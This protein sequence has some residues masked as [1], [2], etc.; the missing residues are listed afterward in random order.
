MG[1]PPI[2]VGGV[3]EIRPRQIKDRLWVVRVRWRDDAGDYHRT[4]VE[5]P[6][7]RESED[8]AA[9]RV[10][11]A[12]E[13]LRQP[14]LVDLTLDEVATRCFDDMR[15]SRRRPSTIAQYEATWRGT[16]SPILG[17]EPV[18]A[19]TRARVQQVLLGGLFARHQG[20]RA[21]DGSWVPGEYRLDESG[22]RIPLQGAQPRNVLRIVL[23][24]AADRGLRTDGVNPLDGTETP[25]R[26]APAVRALTDEESTHLIE[27]AAHWHR[28][29]H[30]ASDVL[31]HGLVLLRYG[32][33]RLG[34][35]LAL[36]WDDID[37]AS[38]PPTM[39]V[40]HTL[41]EQRGTVGGLGPT[42][43]G[44]VD[45]I[46]LHPAAM[47]I[48]LSRRRASDLGP[49][50]FATRTGRPVTQANF[51]RALRDLVRGTDLAWVHPHAFRKSL[52]TKADAQ[53]NLDAAR[54]LLRHKDN[55]VTRRHY[56][57]RADVRI[58]DPRS[59]FE[60]TEGCS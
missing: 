37:L 7:K 21:D 60:Q 46:A 17:C 47:T 38:D 29:G 6:S 52:A 32:G 19:I 51:R 26:R 33:L 54:D 58:L 15:L 25:E 34:E 53:L 10:A 42:K 4:T 27:M 44:T 24:F 3:G 1:R 50:V 45:V 56:V 2:P 14:S 13:A 11:E 49:F 31:W 35:L 36:T 8:L 12:R 39:T 28:T 43:G 59:L 40:R 18:N 41:L 30:G 57:Q 22:H 48:L 55:A 5:A 20:H 23:R 16:I 9:E